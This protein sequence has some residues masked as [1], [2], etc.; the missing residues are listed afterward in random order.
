MLPEGF[1]V[2]TIGQHGGSPNIMRA[3]TGAIGTQAVKFDVYRPINQKLSE[4]AKSE[5]RDEIEVAYFKNDPYTNVAIRVKDLNDKQKIETAH[6]YERFLSQKDSTDT[7]ID[8][9][10]G[11]VESEKIRLA[12]LGISTVEQL[13]S[14]KDFELQRLG[15]GA[16]DLRDRAQWH[17]KAKYGE[18][19]E[20]SKEMQAVMEENRKLAERLKAL[21]EQM[22]ARHVE[23]A[24]SE[25]GARR[26]GRPKKVEQEEEQV[27]A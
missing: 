3:V 24:K 16:K 7:M 1:K 10:D 26:P 6:L 8:A 18:Q 19:S 12:V 5:V 15:G 4:A 21:E 22:F 20:A 27:P 14:F 11:I 23:A 25:S 2:P 17:M 9:W 13:A